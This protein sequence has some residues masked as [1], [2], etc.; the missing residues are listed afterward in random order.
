[1]PSL[2]AIGIVAADMARSIRFYRLLGLD[3]PETPDAPHV[4]AWL[5]NG[6]RL[7]LDQEASIQAF[8]PSWVRAR[9]NQL[10]LAIEC[11]SPAEV[12]AVRAAVAAEGFDAEEPFDAPWGQR[13]C[14]LHDPDGNPVDLYAA[15]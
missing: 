2:N 13:Y 4:D 10:G 14:E 7:M 6:F 1:M 3:V 8:N 9:G 15:L 11:D 5:P 12:D